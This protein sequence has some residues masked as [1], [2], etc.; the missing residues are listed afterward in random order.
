MKNLLFFFVFMA[1]IT[2][3]ACNTPPKLLTDSDKNAIEKQILDQWKKA[4][5]MVEKADA[6][7]YL[8]AF[9]SNEFLGMSSAG[10]QFVS[11]TEYSDSVK[12]WFSTRNSSE[13]QNASVKVTVLT[14]NLALLDQASVFK[15]NFKDNQVMR[16]SHVV[17][18][19]FKKEG[20]AWRIIHGHES[21][22]SL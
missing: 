17:S 6:E 21:W 16:T 15:V 12:V 9:S 14:E 7:G 1:G 13:I 3:T 10:K 18:F 4:G 5:A 19:I 22:R 8:S 2:F 20:L 11:M